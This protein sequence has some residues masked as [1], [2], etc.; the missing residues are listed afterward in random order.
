MNKFVFFIILIGL[1]GTA[2]FAQ[3]ETMRRQSLKT[4]LALGFNSGYRETGTGLMYTFGWQKS[5]GKKN[6]FRINPNIMIGGFMPFG[7]TDVPKQYFRMTNLNFDLHYDLIRYKPLS[8]VTTLGVFTNFSR[9]LIEAGGGPDSHQ[10]SRYFY[11]FYF[12]GLSSIGLRI[13]PKR[14]KLAFELRPINIQMGTRYFETIFFMF[15]IDFKL[16]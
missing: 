15:N 9:G 1:V 2:A 6:K 10:S 16:K 12:G 7:M 4:G 5:F 8:L 3:Q 11:G 14:S 13:A